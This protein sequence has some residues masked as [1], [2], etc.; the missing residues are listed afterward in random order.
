[1][2]VVMFSKLNS[3]S[4]WIV[5]KINYLCLSLPKEEKKKDKKKEGTFVVKAGYI[6]AD[7]IF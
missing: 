7:P 5:N 4:Q 1:M 3:K 6:F 2:C